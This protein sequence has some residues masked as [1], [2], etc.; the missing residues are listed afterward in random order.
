MHK[1]TLLSG[2]NEGAAVEWGGPGCLGVRVG[3]GVG[4][5]GGDS[6]LAWKKS[7]GAVVWNMFDVGPQWPECFGHVKI[8]KP[9]R[10]L[11][12]SL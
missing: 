5:W 4:G 3:V 1:W 9:I 8:K 10:S 12:I 7:T 6:E 11:Q 2:G